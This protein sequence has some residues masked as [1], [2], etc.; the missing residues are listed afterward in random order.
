MRIVR[1]KPGQESR[2]LDV[3]E[4]FDKPPQRDA[5]RAYLADER[6]IF[7]LASEGSRVAG[8]LRGTELRQLRST[9]PQMFLYE[10]ST[11]PGFLQ[12][13][14]ASRLIQRLLD[15]CRE[16]DFDE[17][18]VLTD[19]ANVAAVKLYQSTGAVTETPADRMLVYHL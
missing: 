7:L 17:V 16:G 2:L 8:F 19:P 12:R 15:Y 1:L 10:V 11:V 9:R 13:G 5:V 18:F 4:L 3:P 6:N 14:V